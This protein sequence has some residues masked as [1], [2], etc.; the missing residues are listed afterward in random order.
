MSDKGK[1]NKIHVLF[2]SLTTSLGFYSYGYTNGISNSS[3]S[4][5]SS[6]LDWNSNSQSLISIMSG[7]VLLG[8]SFGSLLCGLFSQN[9]GKRKMIIMT[10]LIMIIGSI[11]CSYPNTICFGIGRFLCGFASGCF[12]MICSS[13]INEFTPS[14]MSASMGSL[15][16]IFMMLGVLSSNCICMALPLTECKSDIKYKVFLIFSVPGWICLLQM[17]LFIFK[18]T[19]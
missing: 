5:I 10:D 11:F 9:I 4:C 17:L 1:I 13:Y 19:I 18:Y 16:Q 7:I 8:G 2:R 3:I 6:I 12:S 15:N 14:S